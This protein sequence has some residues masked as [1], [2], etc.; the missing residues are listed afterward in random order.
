MDCVGS[1][2]WRQCDED[3]PAT[4]IHRAAVTR[5]S[6]PWQAGGRCALAQV[7]A[8]AD[9]HG[10]GRGGRQRCSTNRYRGLE[11]AAVVPDAAG[12]VSEDYVP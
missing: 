6:R 12:D 3:E 10:T 5:R 7:V 8:R 11:R 4:F 2:R 9:Y 1:E